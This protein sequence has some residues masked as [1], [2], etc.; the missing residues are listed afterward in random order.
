M[1]SSESD[2]SPQHT[3]EPHTQFPDS[4]QLLRSCESCRRKKRKC[5]GDRPSCSRCTAQGEQCVYRPTARFLKPRSNIVAARKTHAKKKRASLDAGVRPRAMSVLSEHM[6]TALAPA[7]L[8]LSP[9]MSVTPAGL[10][11]GSSSDALNSPTDVMG[12]SY[13]GVLPNRSASPR[14]LMADMAPQF[15]Y[16]QPT[17]PQLCD[18]ADYSQLLAITQQS[19]LMT[20]MPV[21]P[22]MPMVS[23]PDP[24]FVPMSWPDSNLL[25]TVYPLSVPDSRPNLDTILPLSK[26]IFSEWFVQ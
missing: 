2:S 9:P 25:S 24:T 4:V 21:Q 13:M 26:N 7:D 3:P 18:A 23:L 1:S 19:A 22:M 6:V 11:P 12:L 14:M 15:M 5:S 10:S 20:S 16:P 8:V 17:V